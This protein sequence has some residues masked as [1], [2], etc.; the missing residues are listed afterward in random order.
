MIP[1]HSNKTAVS[2]GE[3]RKVSREQPG[4][5]TIDTGEKGTEGEI[6]QAEEGNLERENVR[7]DE[8]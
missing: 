2:G 7:M 8:F 4:S 3:N 5:V 6:Q 1:N